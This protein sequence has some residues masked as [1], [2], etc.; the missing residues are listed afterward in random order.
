MVEQKDGSG[1]HGGGLSAFQ[2]VRSGLPSWL[3]NATV[4]I[5]AQSREFHKLRESRR[6]PDLSTQGSIEQVL[7]E[8]HRG[9]TMIMDFTFIPYKHSPKQT[10]NRVLHQD[11]LGY[12]PGNGDRV[13]MGYPRSATELVMRLGD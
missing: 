3:L 6:A 7:K 11:L 13:R 1:D 5:R 10:K 12:S 2:L 4:P 9:R 8:L